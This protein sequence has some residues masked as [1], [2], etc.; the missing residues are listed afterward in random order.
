MV[1]QKKGEL[2]E[3]DVE[4]PAW[5]SDVHGDE[6]QYSED[7]PH[8]QEL[9]QSYELPELL[10]VVKVVGYH[11]HDGGSRHTDHKGVVGDE[12]APCHVPAQSGVLRARDHLPDEE[13]HANP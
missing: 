11:H 6:Q 7:S 1:F 10:L 12:E 2:G 13:G 8:G 3:Q 9:T 5:L 4:H